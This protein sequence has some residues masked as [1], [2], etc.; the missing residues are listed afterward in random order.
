MLLRGTVANRRALGHRICASVRVRVHRGG[1]V[2]PGVPEVDACS[3][4]FAA[5]DVGAIDRN[6]GSGD[7]EL[8]H[9]SISLQDQ[10]RRGGWKCKTR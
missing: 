8:G 3:D 1:R 4:V 5:G 6:V 9:R 2:Q 7:T 10:Q